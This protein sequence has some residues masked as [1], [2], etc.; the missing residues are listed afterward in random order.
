MI[1]IS[2]KQLLEIEKA[3]ALSIQD[4]QEM[5]KDLENLTENVNGFRD[6]FRKFAEGLDNRYAKK[7]SVDK[8]WSIVRAVIAFFF[9]GAG[10]V[11]ISLIF[12]KH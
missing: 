10:G 11:I 1:S 4:R 6:E 3:I 12:I 5:K 9:T 7:T 2:T 8:L